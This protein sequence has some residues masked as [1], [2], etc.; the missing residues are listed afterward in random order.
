MKC[1]YYTC[2]KPGCVLIADWDNSW[3]MYCVLHALKE[4]NNP[5]HWTYNV[6]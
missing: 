1:V 4:L 6:T 2:D 5:E 3:D